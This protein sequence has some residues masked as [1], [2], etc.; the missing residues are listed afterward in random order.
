[1]NDAL[2]CWK[3]GATW[4]GDGCFARLEACRGC[5]AELHVCVMCRLYEPHTAER[6]RE[7]RAEPPRDKTLAN[8]CDY[9]VPRPGAYTGGQPADNSARTALEALF[10]ADTATAQP[11]DET[12][13]ALEALFKKDEPDGR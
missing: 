1:M 5:G 11:A 13:N 6:C 7:E 2:V 12:G 4:Q 10:S 9:F 8:F 3:C